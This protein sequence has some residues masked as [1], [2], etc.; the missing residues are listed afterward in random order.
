MKSGAIGK[1]HGDF[2]TIDT[3]EFPVE[4]KKHGKTIRSSL[5]IGKTETDLY[6]HKV[7]SGRAAEEDAKETE[8]YGINEDGEI[9]L[10]TKRIEVLTEITDLFCVYG[11]YAVVESKQKTFAFDLLGKT[12]G[13]TIEKVEF[14]IQSLVDSHPDATYWMGGFY[15]RHGDVSTG[16]GYGDGDIF[17]DED[18]GDVLRDAAKNRIGMRFDF[19]NQM[20]KMMVTETGYAEVYQPSDF[21]TLEFSRLISEILLPHA[22]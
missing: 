17:E 2:D 13:T 16:D 4:D 18:I 14:D 5:N 21:S 12:T 1:V 15:D 19:E 20:V 6:G 3:S 8:T 22:E 11:E 7:V 10:A 9:G